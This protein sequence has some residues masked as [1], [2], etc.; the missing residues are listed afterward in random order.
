MRQKLLAM[1]QQL[2]ALQQAKQRPQ[3]E[4][5]SSLVPGAQLLAEV[6]RQQ[7]LSQ[8]PQEQHQLARPAAAGSAQDPLPS[9]NASYQHQQLPGSTGPVVSSAGAGVQEPDL[10][11][12]VPP[13]QQEQVGHEKQV[14][15]A[16]EHQTMDGPKQAGYD[17]HR[18]TE[19]VPHLQE[20]TQQQQQQDITSQHDG[21]ASQ[22]QQPAS[23]QLGAAFNSIWPGL[24][25]QLRQQQQH[26]STYQQLLE[27]T[28]ALVANSHWQTTS[29]QQLH[30]GASP[31]KS[32]S[33]SRL[34]GLARVPSGM[35]GAS[36][37][38]K[39]LSRLSVSQSWAGASPGPTPR[40]GFAAPATQQV[41]AGAAAG[42]GEA[43]RARLFEPALGAVSEALQSPLSPGALLPGSGPTAVSRA[44]GSLGAGSAMLSSVGYGGHFLSQPVLTACSSPS[45]SAAL[46]GGFGTML[47]PAHPQ[48]QL[49]LQQPVGPT[50]S[51]AGGSSRPLLCTSRVAQVLFGTPSKLP[52][53]LTVSHSQHSAP[54]AHGC[55][56][57]QGRP[58]GSQHASADCDSK[59]ASASGCALQEGGTPGAASC[60]YAEASDSGGSGGACQPGSDSDSDDEAG[61]GAEGPAH[62]SRAQASRQQARSS[63]RA[64]QQQPRLTGSYEQQA[65]EQ[66]CWTVHTNWAAEL[67]PETAAVAAAAAAAAGLSVQLGR[68][69]AVK[70]QEH[71]PYFVGMC[72]EG[73][74][75]YARSSADRGQAAQQQ[76]LGLGVAACSPMWVSVAGGQQHT[77]AATGLGSVAQQGG[78]QQEQ[79]QQCP[80]VCSPLCLMVPRKLWN[81][82]GAEMR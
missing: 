55:A 43:V 31:L 38:L 40:T 72:A 7:R 3:T 54:A 27:G 39:Q 53:G 56:Q 18:Y 5:G 4:S 81:S 73:L 71:S 10:L 19:A 35:L 16:V 36:P 76:L 28:K 11:Q 70:L 25:Q 2:L 32:S 44:V 79:E 49:Q 69:L 52:A 63:G 66:E 67:D 34:G 1:E 6:Q 80:P 45:H 51:P 46:S 59:P 74:V 15:L 61:Y 29:L 75:Q 17:A 20:S 13:Q 21:Q 33:P 57:Q 22:Q 77:P 65:E 8:P 23:Q 41:C 9:Q 14:A 48:Q 12:P 64:A 42:V 30:R 24:Q 82:P 58:G 60:R 62:G 50:R 78:E 26:T 47:S 37:A 68:G